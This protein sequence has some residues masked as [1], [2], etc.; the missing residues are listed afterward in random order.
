MLE[1]LLVH[2]PVLKVSATANDIPEQDE[3]GPVIVPGARFTVICIVVVSDCKPSVIC[4]L[5]ESGPVYPVV[6]L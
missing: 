5:N 6:G 3:D 1:L 4:I 2:V